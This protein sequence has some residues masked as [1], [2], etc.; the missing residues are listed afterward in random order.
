MQIPD[1]RDEPEITIEHCSV[2]LEKL[3]D[4]L[5]TAYEA[6]ELKQLAGEADADEI[7]KMLANHFSPKKFRE[8]FKTDLGKGVLIGVFFQELFV[9]TEDEDAD[10]GEEGF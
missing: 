9:T 4:L 6:P 10:Q 7:R 8:L 1:L 2:L 5:S 3:G